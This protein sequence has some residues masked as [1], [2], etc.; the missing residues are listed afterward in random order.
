M[1]REKEIIKKLDVIIKYLVT[2]HHI[3]SGINRSMVTLPY[4]TIESLS[5]EVVNEL[6]RQLCDMWVNA[7][8]LP[9]KRQAKETKQ[10]RFKKP[11]RKRR[12]R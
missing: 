7:K 1:F 9:G 2:I 5:P 8:K 3:Q 12:F 10:V 11:L 6:G 4:R